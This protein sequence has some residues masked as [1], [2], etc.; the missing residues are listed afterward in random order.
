MNSSGHLQLP[1]N[2]RLVHIGN[3]W[4]ALSLFRV[5]AMTTYPTSLCN[6]GRDMFSALSQSQ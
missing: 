5:E 1:S 4:P 3:Y 2:A 6:I